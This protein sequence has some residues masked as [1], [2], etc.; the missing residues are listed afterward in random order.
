MQIANFESV[1]IPDILEVENTSF[2]HPWTE[3]MFL[4]EIS[5]KFSV[6]RVVIKDGKAIAY[7]GMWVLADEGHITNI[8]VSK[9]YRRQG[10][11]SLLLKDF[12]DLAKEKNLSF[13]TLE[14]RESNEAARALYSSFGFCE[15]GRRKKYYENTEDAI[16]MTKY[17]KEVE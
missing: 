6:Y 13:M 14:V 16:L 5:G 4:E 10:V 2:S 9:N 12:I 15:V 7:M 3:K 11:A 8:A 1:H 17:F